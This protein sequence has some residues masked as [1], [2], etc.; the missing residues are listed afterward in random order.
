MSNVEALKAFAPSLEVT[1]EYRGSK[2]NGYV[3]SCDEDG[4]K[5]TVKFRPDEAH[6]KVDKTHWD[7]GSR[8]KYAVTE[9][10]AGH[11]GEE[12]PRN[13]TADEIKAEETRV[14][15]YGV[16]FIHCCRCGR[17]VWEDPCDCYVTRAP[18][19]ACAQCGKQHK[20]ASAACCGRAINTCDQ[21]QG[22][23]IAMARQY[24]H[25]D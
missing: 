9:L 2:V 11:S 8:E 12:R 18:G 6:D 10:T 25:F 24:G 17:G 1:A 15:G 21:N 20:T 22:W 16:A 14:K 13:R 5:V 4:T 3:E 7:L 23:L 19:Y